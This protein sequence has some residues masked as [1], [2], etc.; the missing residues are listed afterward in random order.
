MGLGEN[1]YCA[2]TWG[3]F[4]QAPSA[5]QVSALVVVNVLVLV[6]FHVNEP[7]VKRHHKVDPR[8]VALCPVKP[9]CDLALELEARGLQEA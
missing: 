9:H 2:G 3:N 7:V 1:G 5:L 8:I 6:H 4:E